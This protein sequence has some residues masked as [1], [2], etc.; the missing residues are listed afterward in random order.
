MTYSR[1]MLKSMA[2]LLMIIDH[3]G[4]FLLDNNIL[5]RSIGRLSFPLFLYLL[6]DGV[7]HTRDLEKY[8]RRLILFWAI[9]AI[10]YS[11]AF[12][13]KF[14]GAAQNIF[15]TL[16][17]CLVLFCILD[18]KECP[19]W[20]KYLITVLMSMLASQLGLEYSW[21]G[22]ALATILYY[23]KDKGFLAI[24]CPMAVISAIYGLSIGSEITILTSLSPVF[25][26]AQGI[27]QPSRRPSKVTSVMAYLFYP[28]H[29]LFFALIRF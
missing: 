29:L 26:P 10:P 17:L 4:L 25:F 21:Y 1:N 12:Y 15:A 11:L 7:L 13:G 14:I 24:F 5:C 27:F 20:G 23:Q 19:I 18:N 16:F 6:L 2:I 28:V 8:A 22:I 3:I 9:S